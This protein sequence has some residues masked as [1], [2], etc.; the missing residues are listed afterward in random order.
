M[1]ITDEMKVFSEKIINKNEIVVNRLL[2]SKYIYHYT[3]QSGL[4][5]IIKNN[6][7]WFSDIRYLNDK[8]EIIDGIKIACNLKCDNE[9]DGL[10]SDNL[11]EQLFNIINNETMKRHFFVCCFSIGSDELPLWNYYTK[12]GNSKGYNIVLD[13]RA[14]LASIIYENKD[15]LR[16]CKVTFGKV[17]YS[18][19]IKKKYANN[20]FGKFIQEQPQYM[21][22][23]FEIMVQVMNLQV[24]EDVIDQYLKDV[25]EKYCF[26]NTYKL[27][28]ILSFNGEKLQFEKSMYSENVVYCK[29][30]SFSHEKETRIVIEIPEDRFNN[31]NK[32][33]VFKVFHK[34]IM[35]TPY[36]DLKFDSHCIQGITLS[37]TLDMDIVQPE[38]EQ[39]FLEN[40]ID[41]YKFEKGIRKSDI[42]IRY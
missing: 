9:L 8:E 5:G 41:I 25:S 37:S 18:D 32:Q 16:D 42:P 2:R 6:S 23:L 40:K 20:I 11:S 13:Y 17:E 34:G 21:K 19:N 33:G 38:L 7:L 22:T 3:S 27:P 1:D 36:L 15:V 30:K 39:F 26:K 10:D 4:E 28:S 31:L 35:D 24:K 14:L 12:D 29:K